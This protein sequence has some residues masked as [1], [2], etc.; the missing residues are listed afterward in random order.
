MGSVL[1]PLYGCEPTI[2]VTLFSCPA[3]STIPASE[4][5]NPASVKAFCRN[6]PYTTGELSGIDTWCDS[7]ETMVGGSFDTI[8]TD[9]PTEGASMNTPVVT[10]PESHP[11]SF[12]KVFIFSAKSL[13]SL[14]PFNAMIFTKPLG[15]AV[16]AAMNLLRCCGEIFLQ[17][18]F[19]CNSKRLCSAVAALLCCLA[20]SALASDAAVSSPAN[21]VSASAARCCCWLNPSLSASSCLLKSC[22]C[23]AWRS[24][25]ILPVTK[26]PAP[27]TNVRPTSSTGHPIKYF[28]P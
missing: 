4:S 22:N 26:A 1:I 19:C 7:L 14:S 11:A 10:G 12:S 13:A 17:F 16:A 24:L 8:I 28:F 3:D 23:S 6:T 9:N 18:S 5:V 15:L 25:K 27:A 21:L 2:S 20:I